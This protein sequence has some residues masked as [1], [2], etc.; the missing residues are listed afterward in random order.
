MNDYLL[1]LD[2]IRLFLL[3][4]IVPTRRHWAKL[5]YGAHRNNTTIRNDLH[6]VEHLTAEKET[7]KTEPAPPNEGRNYNS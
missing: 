7:M 1:L 5:A 3:F 4:P 2:S 6:F